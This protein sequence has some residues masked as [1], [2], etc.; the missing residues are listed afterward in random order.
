MFETMIQRTARI[1]RHMLILLFVT[2]FPF[3]AA[4][5]EDPLA[6]TR[7]IADKILRETSFET[8][9]IPL[10][11]GV[12]ITGFT[13]DGYPGD[14]EY[15][16]YA[17][18]LIESGQEGPGQ[19]G[20]SFA[21]N[22]TLFLNGEP[23]F[24]G[25]SDTLVIHE[26]TYDRFRFSEK[27]QVR[28]KKGTNQLL[29]RCD[30]GKGHTSLMI[31]PQDELDAKPGTLNSVPVSDELSGVHWIVSGPWKAMDQKFLPES[32]FSTSYR[33]GDDY[34]VWQ[35][36]RVPLV[37]ELVIPVSA[38]YTRDAYADWNYAN[39]G[40]MLGI[41]NLYQVT[42]DTVYLDF[43]RRYARNVEENR[44][45]FRWQYETLHAMRGS[46]H[47]LFRMTMLDDSGGP[48]LPMAEL[49]AN[50][51]EGAGHMSLLSRVVDYVT[52]EQERLPD[53]TLCRPEP[54]AATVWA[55]DLFM[56]VPFLLRM[57]RI[58]GD[59][60]FY[61]EVARQVIQ[62]NRYLSDP[63]TGLW[64]HGWFNERQE[65]APV[66]WGRANG[67]IVWATSEA[68]M[69]LPEEHPDYA[70]ILEIFRAH[71]Q[72]LGAYQDPEGM[73]HQVLDHPETFLETSCTAMFTLGMA[74][75]VRLGWLDEGYR[76]KALAG[77]KALQ[78][79][80][81]PDGTVKDICRGTG[82]GENV[83]FYEQRARFDHDP[84]GLGAMLTAGCEIRLM[85]EK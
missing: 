5:Q 39:G 14:R 15:T 12:G 53:G 68:L 17:Y 10:E 74:R 55:D 1:Y 38:S 51:P 29:V 76:A 43:V 85:T 24:N 60:S 31:L 42:G 62:F 65:H 16:W 19:L 48:A 50:D 33:W 28:W 13:L 26:Y 34:I 80:I 20:L 23:V 82:I 21:G 22:I 77:W 84:R 6:T 46:F 32:G 66:R 71:M 78:A 41:L 44:D 83:A 30:P 67:W 25:S 27:L 58:T 2:G 9:M 47:R 70:L 36:P 64:F 75:G 11:Y 37:R 81:G 8:R 54:E 18:S 3:A 73:W 40:T 79:K 52:D 35:V 49:Q 63:G 45:Y 61:D 69:Q 56:T 4:S 7:L 72:A 59:S 57:A